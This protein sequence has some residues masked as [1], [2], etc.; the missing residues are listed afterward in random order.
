M[1]KMSKMAEEIKASAEN[2]N[3]EYDKKIQD[4]ETTY[5]SHLITPV[6]GTIIDTTSPQ[7]KSTIHSAKI[8]AAEALSL[9]DPTNKTTYFD[10][11]GPSGGFNNVEEE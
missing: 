8:P 11:I 7:G 3:A 9:T 6:F 2:I 1:S 4:V 5:G 10:L